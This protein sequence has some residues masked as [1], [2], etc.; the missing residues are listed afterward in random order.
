MIYGVD[1]ADPQG[2]VDFDQL[3]A[4]ACQFVVMKATEGVGFTAATFAR[5]QAEARRV[6]IARGYYHFAC[7]DLGNGPEAEADYFLSV[8]GA[9][10][11]GELLLLD[12]ETKNDPA[13]AKAFLDHVKAKSGVAALLYTMLSYLVADWMPVVA[14]GY[15]LWI[16]NPDNDPGSTPSTPWPFVALKQYGTAPASPYAGISTAVDLDVFYGDL[17]Q[18]AKYGQQGGIDMTPAQEAK[19]DALLA[20]ADAILARQ[21]EPMIWT[22]RAQRSLDVETGK[23]FDQKTGPHDPRIVQ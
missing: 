11:D 2:T 13:W 12:L 23:V 16:A 6:G 21:D 17:T 15:G 22:A 1:I 20:K 5:N 18:L 10:E 7:N 8:V 14:A 9:L 4:S 3:K 19:L